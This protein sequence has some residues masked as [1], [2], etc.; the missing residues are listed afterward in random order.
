[1]KHPGHTYGGFVPAISELGMTLPL[2]EPIPGLSG[3]EAEKITLPEAPANVS[4]LPNIT[5]NRDIPSREI[6]TRFPF[7]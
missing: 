4:G 6:L 2:A 3:H 5:V 7:G 1:M